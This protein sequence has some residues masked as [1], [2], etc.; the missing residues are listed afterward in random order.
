[1]PKGLRIKQH[2]R[3]K[4]HDS[5]GEMIAEPKPGRQVGLLI[6]FLGRLGHVGLSAEDLP[7]VGDYGPI[8]EV[9]GPLLRRTRGDGRWSRGYGPSLV[10][11]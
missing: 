2:P 3:R 6:G 4:Y 11:A 10:E 5:A 1:M 7:L 8:R 9:R